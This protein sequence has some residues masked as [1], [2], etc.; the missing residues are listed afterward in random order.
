MDLNEQSRH[1]PKTVDQFRE[2]RHPPNA[3]SCYGPSKPLAPT[4]ANPEALQA[5]PN[6]QPWMISH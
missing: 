4:K 1:A 5:K 2:S 3:C 6:G